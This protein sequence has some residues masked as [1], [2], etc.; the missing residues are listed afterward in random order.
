MYKRQAAHCST[1]PRHR[2]GGTGIFFFSSAVPNRCNL[3]NRGLKKRR[4]SYT[5]IRHCSKHGVY[6]RLP[7]ENK[8]LIGSSLSSI[9]S[10][11][12]LHTSSMQ[13]RQQ[14]QRSR[15]SSQPRARLQGQRRHP[16][17]PSHQRLRRLRPSCSQ[18]PSLS[19]SL[20]SLAVLRALSALTPSILMGFRR[21][22]RHYCRT[23]VNS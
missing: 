11:H 20:P 9:R 19:P 16:Q 15:G 17:S 8:S 13:Q 18:C 14:Q 22:M 7:A 6:S 3:R 10:R 4:Y 2:K 5:Y 1:Q 12:I 21:F 23:Y